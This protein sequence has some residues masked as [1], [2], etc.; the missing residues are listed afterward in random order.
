M[1]VSALQLLSAWVFGAKANIQNRLLGSNGLDSRDCQIRCP[2]SRVPE[3]VVLPAITQFR[4]VSGQWKNTIECWRVDTVSSSVPGVENALRLNW[5]HGFDAAY[6]YMFYEQSFMPA[7]PAPEPSLIVM[8][9]GIG[10]GWTIFY[11]AKTNTVLI[12][13]CVSR[14]STGTIRSMLESWTW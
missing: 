3:Q 5:E 7:H 14:R 1:R 10:K 8:S 9:S 2:A 4:N 11:Q 12:S 6:Q 13:P